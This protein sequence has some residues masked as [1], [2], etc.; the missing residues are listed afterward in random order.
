MLVTT[1]RIWLRVVI[2]FFSIAIMNIPLYAAASPIAPKH[3]HGHL[4]AD[5]GVDMAGTRDSHTD[6]NAGITRSDFTNGP[7][8]QPDCEPNHSKSPC[9]PG[10]Y[11]ATANGVTQ[12]RN[13]C[14]ASLFAHVIAP[15]RDPEDV[16]RPPKPA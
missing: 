1:S 6:R 7:V 4:A 3:V 13:D 15:Q 16:F 11:L 8:G 2:V 5:L 12:P 10:C 9:C 14:A